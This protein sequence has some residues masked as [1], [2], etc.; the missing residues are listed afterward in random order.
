MPSMRVAVRYASCWLKVQQRPLSLRECPAL[1][2]VKLF[3]LGQGADQGR[4]PFC[5]I[6]PAA[7]DPCARKNRLKRASYPIKLELSFRREPRL[8]KRVP[9]PNCANFRASASISRLLA[10]SLVIAIESPCLTAL[11]LERAFPASVL[12]PRLS[13]PLRRLLATC[14]SVAI[15]SVAQF[16]RRGLQFRSC[17]CAIFLRYPLHFSNCAWAIFRLGHENSRD[18]RRLLLLT[19]SPLIQLTQR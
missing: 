2:P 14:L 9:A 17:I 13:A 5:F 8:P 15:T 16:F 11:R 7:N 10:R 3:K 6:N 19:A 12:G 1:V 18:L 4:S